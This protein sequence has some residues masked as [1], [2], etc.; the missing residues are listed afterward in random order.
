MT[1]R[2]G[3]IL[4]CNRIIREGIDYDIIYKEIVEQS[5]DKKWFFWI[6]ENLCKLEDFNN[7]RV[8]IKSKIFALVKKHWKDRPNDFMEDIGDLSKHIPDKKLIKEIRG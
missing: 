5:K 6:Y 4:D 2:E 3:D 1:S 7:A 8:P